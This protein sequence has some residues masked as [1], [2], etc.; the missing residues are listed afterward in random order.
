MKH[1]MN[2]KDTL[3]ALSNIDPILYEWIEYRC[4]DDDLF[5]DDTSEGCIICE[6]CCV[7]EF[8]EQSVIPT[9]TSPEEHIIRH[10]KDKV[11]STFPYTIRT[12]DDFILWMK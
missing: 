1:S 3:D 10:F 2:K 7:K 8:L 12:E 6:S 4:I 5:E 11:P 9:N